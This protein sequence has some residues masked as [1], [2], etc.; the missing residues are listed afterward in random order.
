MKILQ[1][2]LGAMLGVWVGASG[3]IPSSLAYTQA[4]DECET[5]PDLTCNVPSPLGDLIDVEEISNGGRHY[6]FITWFPALKVCIEYADDLQDAGWS[7]DKLSQSRPEF[8]FGCSVTATDTGAG[9]LPGR[10][11]R[12]DVSGPASRRPIIDGC[13]WP[14]RPTQAPFDVCKL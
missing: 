6:R 3:L 9:G 10:F 8:G 2:L 7:I 11:L 13:I 14:T 5:S 1:L 4:R 12:L